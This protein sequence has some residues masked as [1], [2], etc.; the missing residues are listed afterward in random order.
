MVA[1]YSCRW[2]STSAK[3]TDSTLTVRKRLDLRLKN[4]P[5]S[6]KLG[7]GR[8]KNDAE[9]RRKLA[10]HSR[11]TNADFNSSR[12]TRILKPC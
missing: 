8:S 6:M 3:Q 9:R 11:R 5:V 7:R 1:L 10:E 2:L 4:R 12:N